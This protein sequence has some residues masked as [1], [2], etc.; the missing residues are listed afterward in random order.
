MP[1]FSRKFREIFFINFRKI[2]TQKNQKSYK[3][4]QINI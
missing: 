1:T 4:F 3:E 2:K